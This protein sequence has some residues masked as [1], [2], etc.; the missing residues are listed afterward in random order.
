MRPFLAMAMFS[1]GWFFIK[2]IFERTRA[3]MILSVVANAAAL[4]K[5]PP[6]ARKHQAI[7][8]HRGGKPNLLIAAK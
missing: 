6:A 2:T 3:M 7:T 4:K 5:Y 8:I 1:L